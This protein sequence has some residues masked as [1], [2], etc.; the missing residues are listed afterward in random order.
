ML[1]TLKAKETGTNRRR[2]A[3][4]SR[5]PKVAV[6]FSGRVAAYEYSQFSLLELQR[7]Y[8][9]T[10]FCSLNREATSPYIRH[11]CDI[12][13]ISA[14]QVSYEKPVNPEWFSSYEGNPRLANLYATLYHNKR[15]F[16]LIESYMEK[17]NMRFDIILFY[18]ADLLV[19]T[20][21]LDLTQP[22]PNTVYVPI[23]KGLI[24]VQP[25]GING[26]IAYG[27][28]NS[29]KIYTSAVDDLEKYHDDM[30]GRLYHEGVLLQHLKTKNMRINQFSYMVSPNDRELYDCRLN[31]RRHDT[32]PEYA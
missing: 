13:S 20:R 12:F 19:L 8:N 3:R 22:E 23:D 26:F 4:L 14:E 16:N 28:V 1:Y 24:E 27:D 25:P 6:F 9:A 32:N 31:P 5:K 29:M 21:L 18:R 15:A 10:F 17:Y 11:F 7:K 2:T 30:K